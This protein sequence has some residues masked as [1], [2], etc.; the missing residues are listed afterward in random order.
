M[1]I[2]RI[3][4]L[5]FFLVILSLLISP[6]NAEFVVVVEPEDEVVTVVFDN[7]IP[8]PPAEEPPAEEPPAEEPEEVPGTETVDL[9]ID[10]ND[11]DIVYK[12]LV[13]NLSNY[14]SENIKVIEGRIW[15]SRNKNDTNKYYEQARLWIMQIPKKNKKFMKIS[16]KKKW[17]KPY[18]ANCKKGGYEW[19]ITDELMDALNNDNSNFEV[20]IKYF[21]KEPLNKSLLIITYEDEESGETGTLITAS[22]DVY[23]R[24]INLKSRRSHIKAHIELPEVYDLNEIDI[25]SVEITEVD[26]SQIEAIPAVTLPG[27][28]NNK[29]NDTSHLI[30]RFPREDLKKVLSEEQ[31]VYRKGQLKGQQ[32]ACKDIL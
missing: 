19:N 3:L 14:L 22:V 31:C 17:S 18:T 16:L 24:P 32:R 11:S 23:P 9:T 2:Q 12:K 1:K 25:S 29:K 7:D 21:N 8:E 26:G 27:Y 20:N 10:D 4:I 30:V 6:L 13:F 5:S 15:F 28:K